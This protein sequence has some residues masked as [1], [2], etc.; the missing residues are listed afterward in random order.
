MVMSLHVLF[1]VKLDLKVPSGNHRE[2]KMEADAQ[3]TTVVKQDVL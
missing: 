3:R 1:E 2:L